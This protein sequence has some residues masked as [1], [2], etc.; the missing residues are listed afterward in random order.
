MWIKVEAT[1][2]SSPLPRVFNRF[3]VREHVAE[4]AVCCPPFVGALTTSQGVK[5]RCV[6]QLSSAPPADFIG[7]EA[8]HAAIANSMSRRAAPPRP[9]D[10]DLLVILEAVRAHVAAHLVLPPAGPAGND[11]RPF[12]ILSLL[13]FYTANG[14]PPRLA[15]QELA[16]QVPGLDV[17]ELSA[18]AETDTFWKADLARKAIADRDAATA[19]K[20]AERAEVQKAN[21][22]AQKLNTKSLREM[23]LF[24]VRQR[25]TRREAEGLGPADCS[26]GPYRVWLHLLSDI[27]YMPVKACT[28]LPEGLELV[29]GNH[30]F[31][32]P[33]GKLRRRAQGPVPIWAVLRSRAGVVD[34]R[35]VA[36][37]EMHDDSTLDGEWRIRLALKT[38]KPWLEKL[39]IP[40]H[41]DIALSA[42]VR[43]L[44]LAPS[45]CEELWLEYN[46]AMNAEHERTRREAIRVRIAM[47]MEGEIAFHS[48]GELYAEPTAHELDVLAVETGRDPWRGALRTIVGGAKAITSEQIETSLRAAGQLE[49]S[50]TPVRHERV[51]RLLAWLGFKKKD[52][53]IDGQRKKAFVAE[54]DGEG[55]S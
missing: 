55:E 41:G 17:D 22:A 31:Q 49:G 28:D 46:P 39:D 18:M 1:A 23:G 6:E 14:V 47:C 53:T 15:A 33:V 5:Y 12:V 4:F 50:M 54:A 40:G 7:P 26:E 32:I 29:D 2:D 37:E 20:L 45:L 3:I 10:A 11:P 8:A 19:A 42:M 43:G 44:L 52:T 38:A 16:A 24:A 13:G 25:K 9:G 36:L 21:D 35:P 48:P 27:G 51:S 30:V 34:A